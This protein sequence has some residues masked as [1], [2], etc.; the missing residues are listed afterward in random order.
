MKNELPAELPPERVTVI[1]DPREQ[2]PWDLRPLRTV[3]QTLDTADYAVLGAEH[4]CR[5]ERKTLP[6]FV[7]CCGVERDRFTRE[8]ER[9]W[10]FPSRIVII[11]SSLAE[12]AAGQWR[13]KIGAAAVIGSIASWSA[14]GI[15][16]LFAGD[17]E[18]AQKLAAK[19]LYSAA[20]RQWVSA[21][22][23]VGEVIPHGSP[24]RSVYP[25]E[26]LAAFDPTLAEEAVA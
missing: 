11:E 20:K 1:C 7:S 15:S 24:T 3:R 6:D 5:V 19:I 13:S 10:A 17:R 16:F 9:L 8:L 2:T 4:L 26:T 21:R 18:A 14:M 23:L 12:I 25:P 22:K